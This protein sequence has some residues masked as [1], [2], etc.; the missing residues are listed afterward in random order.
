MNIPNTITLFRLF[1]VPLTVWL[2]TAG[3]FETAFWIFIGAGVSDGLDG[4]IAKRF[5]QVTEL[6]AYLDPIADKLLLVSLFVTLGSQ[7]FIP[8]WLVILVVSRDV[9][10]VGAVVLGW[11]IS[12]EVEVRPLLVSKANTL[13][14]LLLVAIVLAEQGFHRESGMVNDIFFAIVGVTTLWS[15]LSYMLNWMGEQSSPPEIPGPPDSGA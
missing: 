14:Q 13:A 9:M 8:S 1:C 12:N 15:G 2:L 4:Y 10:I 5:D 7:D 6:G 3:F 11:A